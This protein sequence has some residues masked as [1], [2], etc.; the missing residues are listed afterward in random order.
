MSLKHNRMM[1]LHGLM[2][3]SDLSAGFNL[4]NMGVVNCLIVW[5][6][7]PFWGKKKSQKFSGEGTPP[8]QTTLLGASI[9]VP[10]ALNLP[11]KMKVLDPPVCIYIHVISVVHYRSGF[12]DYVISDKVYGLW[13]GRS[14]WT[15][16]VKDLVNCDI[17]CNGDCKLYWAV[18]NLKQQL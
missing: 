1:T 8:P 17:D 10:S 4:I 11:P 13:C 18:G 5:Q 3:I 2:T 12:H 6:N 7:A 14:C 9:L 16:I 15:K